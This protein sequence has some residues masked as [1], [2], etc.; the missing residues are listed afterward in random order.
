VIDHKVASRMYLGQIL[1][2]NRVFHEHPV[3]GDDLPDPFTRAVFEAITRVLDSGQAANLVT[4]QG[5]CGN[6]TVVPPG[7]LAA[8]TNDVP[9]TANAEFYATA[10]RDHAKRHRLARLGR[11]LAERLKSDNL[12]SITDFLESEL[13]AVTRHAEIS[14]IVCARD[15]MISLIDEIEA[16][17]KSGGALPGLPTGFATLDDMILGFQP[18]H[19]YY[20]GGRPSGGKSALAMS[21]VKHLITE[22]VK[23][24]VISLESSRREFLKRLLSSRSGIGSQKLASGMLAA[25]DFRDLT[26]AAGFIFERDLFIADDSNATMSR[27]RG[28]I[29]EMVRRFGAQIVFV[30]YLQLISE[31]RSARQYREHVAECSKALKNLAREL[32]IPIVVLAQLRRDA[33]GRRPTLADFAESGQIERDADVAILI[34]HYGEGPDAQSALL[35]DKNRDGRTGDIR[36]KFNRETVTFSEEA[37]E[38]VAPKSQSVGRPT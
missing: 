11:E 3:A 33:D 36:V 29:R 12:E 38:G 10:I 32:N 20:I 22:K 30:D 35:V 34:H 18:R 17:Y 21:I 14:H 25:S 4:V 1:L 6:R 26:D 16:S 37:S 19:I 5:E 31:D 9:T 7:E 27:V 23:V 8:L 24:G 2:D 28:R 15:E 13:T